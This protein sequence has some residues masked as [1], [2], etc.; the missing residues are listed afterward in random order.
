MRKTEVFIFIVGKLLSKLNLK[1]HISN[2]FVG[3]WAEQTQNIFLTVQSGLQS[4]QKKLTFNARIKSLQATL[5][6]KI[7]TGDFAS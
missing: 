2:F 4:S 5:P 6:D 7:F 3:F 1:M